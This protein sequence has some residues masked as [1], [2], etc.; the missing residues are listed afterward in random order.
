MKNSSFTATNEMLDTAGKR[1]LLVGDYLWPWYQEACAD[2][3]ESHGCVVERFGWL[4]DFRS[5]VEGQSE[6]LYHSFW[7][8]I[9][10]RL[11]FGP[12]VWRVNLRLISATQDFKPDIVWF[13]NVTLISAAT[14]KK[15]RK[16]C[17]NVIFFQYSNDNPFSKAAK[18]S[19]WRN[20]LASM[21]H[22]DVHGVFRHSN[23]SD[24]NKL[25][26]KNVYLLR[27]Y[28]IPKDDYPESQTS[29]PQKFKCD[30]VFAGH[31]EDDGRV[32]MLEAVC[33]AGFK[34]NLFGGGWTAALPRLSKDSPLHDLFPVAPVTGAD[35]RSAIC[36]AKVALCFL[37]TLN[38][39]TYTTRNFQI[40]AMKVAM[41]SQYTDDLATMFIPDVEAVFFRNQDEL[42]AQLKTL[43]ADDQKRAAI[44]EAGYKKVYS[45]GHDVG[46]R[47]GAWLK[48]LLVTS[49]SFRNKTI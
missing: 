44:A 27:S 18:T 26:L 49:T 7:H 6:P 40:P 31:Y 24:C 16:L 42:L 45:E 38:Q 28:F 48:Y 8:R 34:L 4:R 23:I 39:D 5:F 33:N 22:F 36:G 1:I 14:V 21:P 32:E 9:Q 13:Y 11:S 20:F 2:A 37:S 46:A 3:L 10:Y 41:L 30:V 47:M 15:L 12:V 43:I 29:I 19:L 17:P 35:Y 25:G